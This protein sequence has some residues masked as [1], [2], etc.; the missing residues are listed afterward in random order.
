[1]LLNISVF[2]WFGAVAPWASFRVNN[3]IPTYRLVF[4][5][6]LILL[7]RRMPIVFA[8]HKK[9]YQIEEWSQA[10]FVGFFGPIGVSAI[11]YLY[12]SIDFLDQVTV[13]GVVREDAAH[14]QEVLRVVVWFLAICSIVVHGLSIPMGKLGYHLPRSVSRAL[15]TSQENEQPQSFSI[16]RLPSG[17]NSLS[18]LRRRRNPDRVPKAEAFQI[19]GSRILQSPTKDSSP[20]NDEPRR[21][22]FFVETPIAGGQTPRDSSPEPNRNVS[23]DRHGESSHLKTAGVTL[24]DDAEAMDGRS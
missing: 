24:E 7:F 23:H 22:I 8:L 20:P 10:A 16:G 3:V 13:D 12:I 6:V 14:L 21:P 9:I 2:I 17:S 15:S 19:G 1:M 4:L 5:G 11:F 18:Q